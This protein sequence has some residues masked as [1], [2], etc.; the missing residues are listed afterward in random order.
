MNDS[1]WMIYGAYGYTGELVAEE[2]V[3]RGHRPVLA[4][5]SSKE[6]IPLAERLDLDWVVVNLQDM[7]SLTNVVAEVDL[8]FHAAGPVIHTSDRMILACLAAGTN[9]VDISGEI[10]VFRNT[11]SYDQAAVESGIALISGAGFDV[12]ASDCMAEHATNQVHN[13]VELEIAIATLGRTSPG[14]AKTALELFPQ[15]GRIR[16]DGQLLPYRWG[17]GAK[18]IPFPHAVR[19]V[20]PIPWGDLTTAFQTTGVPNITTYM[21][22][23]K[24]AIRLV[25]W[26]SPV[27]QR[28]LKVKLIR[29][30]LQKWVEKNIHGPDAEMRQKG[31]SYVWVR[32]ADSRGREAQAW[33]ETLEAY[34]FTAVGGVRCV[35]R[36]LEE[37]PQGALTP[38]LAFGADFVLQIEGTRR[39][40][41]LP[42]N[43]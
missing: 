41:V 11:F 5:R 3:C 22:L 42:A 33:L 36:V 40:D 2:A 6:L 7:G 43:A 1:R 25:R 18:E 37:R 27:A 30:A 21:A 14:T 31:R 28:V 39:F 19:T 29:R 32:A 35:E 24:N 10:S 38:A 9:Y 20:V 13:A 4:G 34:Q 26:L 17:K 16:R 15:G 8:V 23:P 12:I